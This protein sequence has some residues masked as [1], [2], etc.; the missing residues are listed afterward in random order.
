MAGVVARDD[1]PNALDAIGLVCARAAFV[2]T[3]GGL[4]EGA[5]LVRA[6]DGAAAGLVP[7]DAGLWFP[8]GLLAQL[9]ARTLS[10]W[11]RGPARRWRV[12]SLAA[13]ALFVAAVAGLVGGRLGL[14][15]VRWLPLELLGALELAV[16]ATLLRPEPPFRRAIALFG[17]V[18]AVAMQLFAAR[19]T[20]AHRAFA[21]AMTDLAWVPR[22]M[23][24]LVLRRIA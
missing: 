23:L 20:D 24:R 19:W 21:G 17:L 13:A 18:L 1:A 4:V 7:A 15:A 12:A 6:L 16:L 11:A 8:L 9:P 3:V 14:G 5:L 22:V 10:P 2:A